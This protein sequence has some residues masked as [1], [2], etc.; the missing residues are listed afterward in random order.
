MHNDANRNDHLARNQQHKVNL[1][2][3]VNPTHACPLGA[4][5]VADKY[6]VVNHHYLGNRKFGLKL[7]NI[8]TTISREELRDPTLDKVGDHERHSHGDDDSCHKHLSIEEVGLRE[9]KAVLEFQLHAAM[10]EARSHHE[11][12]GQANDSGHRDCNFDLEPVVELCEVAC[13]MELVRNLGENLLANKC[14]G[15]YLHQHC[16]DTEDSAKRNFPVFS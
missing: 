15:C 7:D 5:V 2:P 8:E 1:W 3:D 9:S 14:S 12:E 13:V 10:S 4:L 6:K 16:R 11:E